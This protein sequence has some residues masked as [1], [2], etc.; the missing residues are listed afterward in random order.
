[1]HVSALHIYP[2]K[3]CRGHA[4]SEAV[5]EPWGLAGDRRWMVVD[6]DVGFITQREEPRLATV[7]VAVR[8]DGIELAR[9]GKRIFVPLPDADAERRNV[10]VW[11]S[12][13][14][15][16]LAAVPLGELLDGA[17]L[18]LAYMDDPTVRSSNPQFSREEDRV[19]FADGYP[20]LLATDDS[21]ADL[22]RRMPAPLSMDRFRP[23]LVISGAPPWAED[24][25]R[26]VRVG[27]VTFRVVKPCDRCIVTTTDQR[28]G[29]RG[30]AGGEPLRALATFRRRGSQVFFGQNLI[31]DGTGT[32]RIGDPV[33]VL[34]Q[35][36]S[37][38]W[39][40]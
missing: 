11:R 5:V 28:T 26:R 1:M 36:M 29:E 40:A 35:A 8:D 14:P 37:A 24:T 21:L 25:W 12:T 34:D 22:N 10:T 23:N 6:H 3:S 17:A 32:I 31:P 27:E 19:S 38:N 13:V 20:L 39:V 4:L 16:R 9:A 33:E 2:V 18:R 7:E 15:A 30:A